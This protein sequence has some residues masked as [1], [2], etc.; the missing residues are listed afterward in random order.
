MSTALALA[1]VT[2][3]YGGVT[4]VDNVSFEVGKGEFLSVLGPSGSGKTTV[5]RLIG[6]FERPDRGTISIL[7]QRVDAL[8]PYKR[9]TATVFQAGALFPHRSVFDNIAFG[10][11]V[12]KL[13]RAEVAG[14]VRKALDV[15]RLKGIE[16]RYP[17]QLSGGQKQRI[18]LAR[19]LAVE[20]AV[21]LFDEPL[22]ALD[23]GLRLELRSEIKSL[24]E[25]LGFTAVYVT[26]DQS[27]AMAMSDRIV[28]MRN[29]RCEQ[30]DTPERIFATPANEFV[31]RFIGESSCLPVQVDERGVMVDEQRI[32]VP[33]ASTL[34]RGAVR[35]FFRPTW[36][37]LGSSAEQCQ[38]RIRARLMFS[39]FLGDSHRYH[40]EVGGSVLIADCRVPLSARHGELVPM[41]W[42]SRE[43]VIFR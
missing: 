8:P 27:E 13:P 25:E 16:S 24:H 2:K 1:S 12:R 15:V 21:V 32:E 39:E 42:N 9:D 29:G 34:P 7:G 20:P 23:L 19:A 22:S 4:A 5:Q 26:H 11:R 3:R 10:L 43:M 36:L 38:N 41:G 18:A 17:A 6:G 14:R 28:V 30:I 40:L 33:C 37:H 31:F 35:L